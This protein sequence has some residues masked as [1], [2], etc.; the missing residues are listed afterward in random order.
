MPRLQD[1]VLDQILRRLERA[2]DVGMEAAVQYRKKLGRL[3]QEL[4]A[5]RAPKVDSPER[6][7]VAAPAHRGPG[8]PRK[9]A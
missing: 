6:E 8:R 4:A 5:A 1:P 9:V 2:P 3:D 7:E